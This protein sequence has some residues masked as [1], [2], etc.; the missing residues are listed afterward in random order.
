MKR[1]RLF[2]L[3][4]S[5]LTL[6]QAQTPIGKFRAHIPLHSFYS[7]AIDSEYVYAATNNG[8]MLVDKTSLYDEQPT[9][10]NWTKVDGLSDIDITKIQYS[11]T[12]QALIIA[13]DN[14]NLD[15]IKEGKLY[16]LR[17]IRDKQITGSKKVSHIRIYGNHTYLAYP[18]GIVTI[19]LQNLVIEDTWFSKRNGV[20]F[21]TTDISETESHYFMSTESGIFSIPKERS[22]PANFLEW[23]LDSTTFE[24]EFKHIVNFCGTLY[25]IKKGEQDTLCIYSQ[26]SWIPTT[27]HYNV[28]R[29][30]NVAHNELIVCNWDHVEIFDSTLNRQFLANLYLTEN[31][32]PSAFDALTDQ[33]HIWVA[34]AQLGLL[35][36][37]REFFY[38]H[39]LKEN[40]PFDLSV[41]SICSVNGVTVTVPGAPFGSAFAPSYHH[42]SMSWFKNQQWD[43]NAYDFTDYDPLHI[44][45]DLTH[46]VINPQDESDW[47]ISSWG[48][49]LFRCKN[50]HIVTHYNAANSPLDSTESGKTFLSGMSFDTKGNLWLT[51]SQSD[52]MLRM[53]EPNGTWHA[54]NIS[55][56]VL[57]STA[58]DVVADKLLID[59]RGFKW[60]NYPRGSDFNRYNLIAFSENGTY[61]N[62]GDDKFACINMNVAAEVVSSTV[63]CMAED[64]DGEI[65]IGTDKGI[66]VIYFPSKVF[67]G[68]AHPRNILLEQ[69]GYVSVLFE[70]EEIT[71][72]AVDGANRKWIGTNKAGVFLMSED[73]QEQL[74]HFTAEDHPLF[75]NQITCI[76]IDPHSGEVFFGT[77]KG[78]VSYRGTATKGFDKYTLLPVYPNPI[79]SGYSGPVA[80]NGLKERSLC[81]ITDAAGQ[82]VWQGYSNGGE[83]VW[84]CVD[85]FGKRPSTGVYY[86]MASDKDGKERMVAK[87]LFIN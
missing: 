51:N 87:F 38:T 50:Q 23:H 64:L 5:L 20:Q 53:L 2:I 73:G 69:D 45:T 33:A 79:R 44:T 49:G 70:Y 12:N 76:N 11:A 24:S 34:D 43:F 9:R 21:T 57:T 17:D 58:K 62:P 39:V 19:D 25:A 65:W 71:A 67:E 72:I 46:V 36:V 42:A 4:F 54:Y 77:S 85:L 35:D 81:K 13:Y 16:N 74:L 48:N 1:S 26:G 15:I 86:V 66:K 78:L 83:L 82:L 10:S 41:Q 63:Y 84:Y 8:L 27:H 56:G 52:Y 30:L 59:S 3:F 32:L 31:T 47:Y 37:H 28:V 40:G 29:A 80:I 68:T 60:V 55:R 75:A 14:G 22:N 6:S 7:V 18:F 61:D